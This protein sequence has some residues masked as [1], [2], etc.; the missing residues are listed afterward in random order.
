MSGARALKVAE[1]PARQDMLDLLDE[2]RVQVEAGDCISLITIAVHPNREW[3]NRSAGS[4]RMMEI[5]GCLAC[6]MSDGIEQMKS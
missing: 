2:I 6:A 3:T 1:S 5:V 4:L